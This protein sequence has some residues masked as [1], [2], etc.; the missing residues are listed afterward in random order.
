LLTICKALF[1]YPEMAVAQEEY[2]EVLIDWKTK[3]LEVPTNTPF[4]PRGISRLLTEA[5]NTGTWKMTEKDTAVV[6]RP[7]FTIRYIDESNRWKE[8]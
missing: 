2:R 4:Y 6:N 3:G 7:V 1:F 5:E 8:E